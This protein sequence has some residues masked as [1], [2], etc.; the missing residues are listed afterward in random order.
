MLISIQTLAPASDVD[1]FIYGLNEEQAL[2]KI[3]QIESDIRDAILSETTV[4]RTKNA[5]TIVSEYPV[6]HIQI[7]LRLYKSISEI[8]T[9]FDVDCACVAYDGKQVWAAPR[10]LAA[11]VTQTN[12]IDLTRRS[13]SYENRLSKYSHRGFEVYWPQLD[14]SKVDPTIFE[15]AFNRV[16]G[17]ARLLVLEKLPHPQDRD[18][19]LTKR[20]SERGRPELPWNSRFRHQLPGNVK[21]SQPDDVAEWVREDDLSSYHTF[22]LPYGPRYTPKKI[23]RLL[24]QQ[25]LLKNAEWNKPK[26]RE[27]KLHRH[28]AFFG[29]VEDVIGDCCGYCPR[30]VTDEDLAAWEEESKIF[31]SGNIS[32]LKDDP[33]RQEIGSFRPLTD[34]DWTEMAYIGNTTR[35]CQAIVDNDLEGVVDWFNGDEADV[36]RRDHTG[37]TPLQLAVMCSSPEIV[38]CLIDRGARI[39]ARLY[40][41]LT[42]LHLA[43]W[44]GSPEMVAALLDKS[45]ENE[46]E[47]SARE[48]KRK[49]ARRDAA[50]HT[51]DNDE[52]VEM[53]Q[54][55]DEA[56][57]NAESEAEDLMDDDSEA[58]SEDRMTGSYV[59]VKDEKEIDANE[60]NTDDPDVYNVDVVAWDS[61]CSALHLALMAGHHNVVVLLI[62]CYGADVMLPVKLM[63][64]H[65]PREPR[66]AILSLL[67]PLDLPTQKATEMVK[68][69]LGKGASPVQAD[70]NQITSLHYIVSQAKTEILKAFKDASPDATSK[71]INHLTVK[72]SWNSSSIESPLLS[73]IRSGSPAVVKEVLSMGAKPVIDLE[74]FVKAYKASKDSRSHDSDEL[75][76]LYLKSVTQPV[77]EAARHESMVEI[78][79]QLLKM[80]ADVN[81]L[82]ARSWELVQSDNNYRW[83]TEDKSLLDLVRDRRVKLEDF[84]NTE[85]KNEKKLLEQPE[86]LKN[87]EY[88]LSGL[89]KGSYQYWSAQN[90]LERAKYVQAERAK[91]FQQD[92]D[93]QKNDGP[94]PGL[95]E[96]QQ[97]AGDLARK[98]KALENRL[99]EEG[100]KTFYEMYPKLKEK[101]TQVR[102]TS[103]NDEDLSDYDELAYKTEFKF[104]GA[105]IT[106]SKQTRYIQLF[107]AAF[108]GDTE[109]V[110]AL[111][112]SSDDSA[113][114]LQVTV[115]DGNGFDPF[116]IA[117]LKGHQELASIMLDIAAAQY[118]DKKETKHVQ[119][120][121]Q[122]NRA[123]GDDDS[124]EGS[125]VASED[126]QPEFYAHLVDD[127]FTV[128]DVAAL[129]KDVKSD[130]KP[131]QFLERHCEL[132]RVM[133]ADRDQALHLCR[134]YQGFNPDPYIYNRGR[135]KP[136][137]KFHQCVTGESHRTRF[138]LWTY[139]VITNNVQLLEFLLESEVKYSTEDPDELLKSLKSRRTEMMHA[140]NLGHREVVD[141]LIRHRGTLLP[142]HH[143]AERSGIAIE[144][145][146]KY[147]QGLSVYG[148]KRKDW[149]K[150][151][152]YADSI[153][154]SETGSPLLDA[155]MEGNLD[156]IDYLLSDTPSRRYEEFCSRFN[157]DQRIRALAEGQGGISG[158][159]Q[160]W[161][162]TRTNLALHVAIMSWPAGANSRLR[163]LLKK[164]PAEYLETRDA[165]GNTPLHLAMKLRN[166]PAFKALLTEGANQRTRDK[167]GRNLLHTIYDD[168]SNS[169][170]FLFRKKISML[171][172]RIIPV[173]LLERC[174]GV[175]PGSLTPLALF[176]RQHVHDPKGDQELLE[177]MI[178]LSKGKDLSLMDGAGDYPLHVEVRRNNSTRS[179]YLAR[180]RP[181][182]LFR[183]NAT[184]MTPI[185]V[186]ETAYFRSRMDKEPSIRSRVGDGSILDKP[187]QDFI[188][189]DG[190]QSS[191]QHDSDD[192]NDDLPL[193]H[194]IYR[195]L[196]RIARQH[197]QARQ[198][199]SVLDANEVARRLA[200]Q[201]HLKN[202]ENRRREAQGL[203]SRWNRYYSRN[204]EDGGEDGNEGDEKMEDEVARLYSQAQTRIHRVPFM[205]HAED[206]AEAVEADL[207][208]WDDFAEAKVDLIRCCEED[209]SE[210]KYVRTRNHKKMTC[211]IGEPR[212]F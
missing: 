151:D 35:L 169:Q 98:F 139:A 134:P 122:H 11:F 128:D 89:Q 201:Q 123:D 85:I 95:K 168:A 58:D 65:T 124:E 175:E 3:K 207:Q 90:D 59:K 39:V 36:N 71:A 15:R 111:C 92:F 2:E 4:V 47:E 23:E 178:Q 179:K 37:R 29:R 153:D 129:A 101:D 130:V 69:L 19:Y 67:L 50:N 188:K 75:R 163:Y 52:D 135:Q 14:R 210:D 113:R 57:E 18:E 13:P 191:R 34:D 21:D 73:A 30:P 112:L 156:M 199:V 100:A 114:A 80:G 192:G 203:K 7:V 16:L 22:T 28:P 144:D 66:A 61:P 64:N 105:D 9:G 25:D 185:E 31:V 142:L 74:E 41:G 70:M 202:A 206:T 197:A 186:A 49:Q 115:T 12:S 166:L 136:W 198:L 68:I 103:D 51:K 62:D 155:I 141:T 125:R 187:V 76:K 5:I 173:L 117:V 109:K 110:K 182:L 132:W 152:R 208:K 60:E 6:R 94:E 176:L 143:L 17:L 56:S 106:P 145:V 54:I 79:L 102:D 43:A 26:D 121:L 183:E 147:Y 77:T 131:A 33:G 133:T 38:Q 44:R 170:V 126:D 167:K 212:D 157:K 96:K 161:M 20:R 78:V 164:V 81:T 171:D 32:F 1:L 46:N 177:V 91:K 165:Q 137:Q 48:E 87:D 189:H 42:A 200:G 119:Y 116:N 190:R 148:Q 10:A 45:A 8:L 40:N 108:A 97:A 99:V 118:E 195:N 158:A 138:S 150:Q 72:N 180:K 120:S 53:T 84:A 196:V 149:A 24:F 107:E 93:A 154:K 27:T 140:M 204:P 146:P 174:S 160:S 162:G 83:N 88:Y 211:E 63:T 172:Q 181:D 205:Q 159:L 82:T 194:P 209:I 55:E 104:H 193:S 127:N 86:A 184:G